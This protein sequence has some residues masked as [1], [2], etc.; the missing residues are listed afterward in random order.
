MI[1]SIVFSP[2]V[3]TPEMFP[4]AK[5]PMSRAPQ[6]GVLT[7]VPSSQRWIPLESALPKSRRVSQ[8]PRGERRW[9]TLTRTSRTHVPAGSPFARWQCPLW[10]HPPEPPS[11]HR[12][13]RSSLRRGAQIYLYVWYVCVRVC[14]CVRGVYVVQTMAD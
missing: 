11:S 14:V 4:S 9:P 8:A 5:P 7:S 13:P 3:L 12:R 6:I 1:L 10:P 2:T